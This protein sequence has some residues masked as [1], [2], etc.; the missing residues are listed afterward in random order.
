MKYY[1]ICGKS[2]KL[3]NSKRITEIDSILSE[4]INSKQTLPLFSTN[5]V[6][7]SF[8]L[9]WFTYL[10]SVFSRFKIAHV[11]SN[12]SSAWTGHEGRISSKVLT[13]IV[14]E[15]SLRKEDL[16]HFACLCGP[17]EFTHTGLDLLKKFGM[18]E[19]DIH[20]FIG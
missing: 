19:N 7:Y 6:T 5:N 16:P 11:L 1:F 13:D 14:D 2:T 17:T 4:V 20:A 9:I 8:I 12:A 15:T 3:S 10:K 18:K